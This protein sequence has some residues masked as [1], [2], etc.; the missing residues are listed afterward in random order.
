VGQSLTVV[1]TADHS[2]TGVVSLAFDENSKP[3]GVAVSPDGRRIYVA[4]GR[5]NSVSVIDSASL[6]IIKTIAV[7]QRVWGIA[8]LPDGNKLYAANGLSNDVSV[9]DTA[10]EAVV[11][12][13]KAGDGP[14]G[15]AVR[16]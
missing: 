3:V 13:I 8:I 4:N 9:I 10:K 14:W 12:T 5:G 15:V 1:N 7:G 6:R 11:A 2:I 16:Q